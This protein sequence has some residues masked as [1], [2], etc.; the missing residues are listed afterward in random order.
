MSRIQNILNKAERD[1]TVRRMRTTT[2]H[3]RSGNGSG[4]ATV[5][6]TPSAIAPPPVMPV[7]APVSTAAPAPVRVPAVEIAPSAPR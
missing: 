3:D 1:G 6:T 5:D 4:V 2:E 7:I